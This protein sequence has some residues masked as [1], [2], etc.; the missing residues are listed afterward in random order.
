MVVEHRYYGKSQPYP[1]WSTQNL[2]HLTSE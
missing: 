2:V 1:D